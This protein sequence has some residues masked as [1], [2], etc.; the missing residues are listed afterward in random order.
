MTP[1]R[2]PKNNSPHL[3]GTAF[4]ENDDFLEYSTAPRREH[5]FRLPR[6][7][8]MS[9]FGSLNDRK[10]ASKTQRKNDA[11]KYTKMYKNN[12]PRDPHFDAKSGPD[13]EPDCARMQVITMFS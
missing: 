1:K 10:S 2:H 13:R 12:S 7:P 3:L 4:H 9:S 11:E 5:E 6:G 8:K